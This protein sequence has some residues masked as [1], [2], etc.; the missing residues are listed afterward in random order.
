LAGVQ[1]FNLNPKK[2]DKKM[3]RRKVAEVKNK[4]R[5]A[6]SPEEQPKNK[7]KRDRPNFKT[8][9]IGVTQAGN[10]YATRIFYDGKPIRLGLFDTKKEAGIAYDQFVID[11]STEEV[12]F[13]LN[14]PKIARSRKK[15]KKRKSKR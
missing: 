3:K 1:I 5:R 10:K 7:K 11:K 14:Y 12:S 4:K 15:E 2:N 6:E 9:L 8:G 13:A